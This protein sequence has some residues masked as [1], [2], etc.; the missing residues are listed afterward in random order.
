MPEDRITVLKMDETSVEMKDVTDRAN[1]IVQKAEVP[2]VTYPIPE[3]QVNVS[4]LLS[5]THYIHCDSLTINTRVPS[6][7]VPVPGVGQVG[8]GLQNT[9]G[10]EEEDDG[11]EGN[12]NSGEE[13]EETITKMEEEE[14]EKE[15]GRGGNNFVKLSN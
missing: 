4:L 14:H 5:A 11:E 2:C 10:L 12:D 3:P 7:V 6:P 9:W 15:I 1:D 8:Q 13:Q